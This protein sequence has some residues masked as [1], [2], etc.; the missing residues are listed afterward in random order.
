MPP[1]I[2]AL[3]KFSK[4]SGMPASAANMTFM[5]RQGISIPGGI[6]VMKSTLTWPITGSAALVWRASDLIIPA[7]PRTSMANSAIVM[8]FGGCSSQCRDVA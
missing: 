7:S 4:A 6:C 2:A 5:V 3:R 8:H 1:A